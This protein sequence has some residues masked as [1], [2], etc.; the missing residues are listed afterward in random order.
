MMTKALKCVFFLGGHVCGLS[1]GEDLTRRDN[2]RA[3]LSMFPQS[4][5]RLQARRKGSVRGKIPSE[6]ADEVGFVDDRL[7][8]V[9]IG[10]AGITL[11]FNPSKGKVIL[12]QHLYSILTLFYLMSQM[13]L[14]RTM[15]CIRCSLTWALR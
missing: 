9:C 11:G 8:M 10:R 5:Y 1:L 3:I 2:A 6:F 12:L 4:L 7:S 13:D 14:K 15:Y